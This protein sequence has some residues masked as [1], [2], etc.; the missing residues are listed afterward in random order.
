[1]P[2]PCNIAPEGR[3]VKCVT[4]SLKTGSRL[5]IAQKYVIIKHGTDRLNI[6]NPAVHT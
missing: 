4:K 5:D 6:A 2:Y 1:M 3:L